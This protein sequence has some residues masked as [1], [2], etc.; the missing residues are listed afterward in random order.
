MPS[1]SMKTRTAE[2]CPWCGYCLRGLPREHRCP[3]CGF[4]YERGAVVAERPRWG[5]M[6]LLVL[7]TLTFL[8]GLYIWGRTG[9]LTLA[10]ATFTGILVAFIGY[11][12]RRRVVYVSENELRVI[13]RSADE[14]SYPTKEIQSA[15]WSGLTGDITIRGH[16]GEVITT[17]GST[18]LQSHRLAK[19]VVGAIERATA[20]M[21][22][23][24][25]L[26]D[27]S[28]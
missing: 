7:N 27:K 20:R 9:K 1:P 23:I 16:D 11:G 4:S 13:G 18:F 28:V 25:A 8:V 3:E 24:D 12:R 15:V 10:L 22:S 26:T 19:Q 5:W 17:I 21:E 6:L 14:Q 2:S